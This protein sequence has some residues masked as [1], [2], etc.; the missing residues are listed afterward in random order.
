[1]KARFAITPPPAVILIICSG[2]LCLGC[3]SSDVYRKG[4]IQS[5]YGSIAQTEACSDK[6]PKLLVHHFTESRG[7]KKEEQTLALC[8]LPVAS[9]YS[10]WYRT[11]WLLWDDRH[12]AGYK[13]AG[14]DLAEVFATAL[15][16][17]GLFSKV[18]VGRTLENTDFRLEGD[19]S[20]LTLR[21]YPHLLGTSIFIGPALGLLGLP[22]GNWEIHQTIHL[23]LFDQH[24][25]ILLWEH[26]FTTNDEGTLAAYYGG[27]PMRCGYPPDKLLIP[28]LAET[29]TSFDE[30]FS[31]AP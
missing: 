28:V 20:E 6:M 25:G 16:N 10:Y 14:Q 7:H 31:W 11:D 27:D 30:K 26:T 3:I 9:M 1:M 15:H 4:A 21:L 2:Y 12:Y 18:E 17:S 13:S 8:L 24:T 19:I 29:I 5:S 22:M 23:R